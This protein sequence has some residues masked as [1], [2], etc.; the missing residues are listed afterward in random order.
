MWQ[1]FVPTAS[2]DNAEAAGSCPINQV[3]G[4]SWLIAI[5]HRIYDASLLRLLGQSWTTKS[6]SLDGDV[7]DILLLIKCR[8]TMG[9]GGHWV[10]SSFDNYVDTW[11]RDQRLPIVTNM[12]FAAS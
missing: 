7:D 6:I 10:A 2:R 9:Y 1:P 5:G 11:M 4:Q 8:Q 3:A 12:R